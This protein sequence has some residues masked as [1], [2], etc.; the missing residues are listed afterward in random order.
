MKEQKEASVEPFYRY[1]GVSKCLSEG[2]SFLT[3]HFFRLLWLTL[4]VAL[5]L[6][7]AIGALLFVQ[8]DESLFLYSSAGTVWTIGLA[9]I[10]F[11]LFAALIATIFQLLVVRSR[12]E[13]WWRLRWR[14]VYG[15][16]W[17]KRIIPTLVVYV[18]QACV[19][20]LFVWVTFKISGLQAEKDELSLSVAKIVGYLVLAMGALAVLVPSSLCLPSAQL[21]EGGLFSLIWQGYR[22]GWRKWGKVFGL[23][24]L[25]SIIINVIS[26]LLCSPAVLSFFVKKEAVASLLQGDAVALP[27]SFTFWASVL[28]VLT[29]Y[30]I[31]LVQLVGVVPQSFLYASIKSDEQTEN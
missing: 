29:S 27:S 4:P 19:L 7:F 30:L 25:S 24:L 9:A 31:S 1:R 20:A 6:A 21:G 14:H 11:L 18:L 28:F 13:E 3:N 22:M 17:L 5:P 2:I 8:S 12:E 26:L 23:A 10:A 16:D 15:V